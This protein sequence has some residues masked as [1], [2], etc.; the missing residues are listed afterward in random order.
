MSDKRR[1]A[2]YPTLARALIANVSDGEALLKD[3]SIT[4]CCIEYTM[5]VDIKPDTPYKLQILPDSTAGIDPFDLQVE[6][7]WI[8]TGGYSCEIGLAI[9][10][11]PKG[12]DFQRYVDY[13]AWR[14]SSV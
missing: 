3:L 9:T 5:F 8:R 13:L 11:S 2:R 12:R 10:A 4:G 6:S 7:R 1:S 14:S